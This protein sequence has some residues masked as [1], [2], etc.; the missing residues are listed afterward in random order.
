[1]FWVYNPSSVWKT[2]VEIRNQVHVNALGVTC[3][4][5]SLTDMIYDVRLKVPSPSA[6]ISPG[7]RK[8]LCTVDI[9]CSTKL[10]VFLLPL[11][12]LFTS[13]DK[14]IRK[15]ISV[16]IFAPTGGFCLQSLVLSLFISML[17]FR[18]YSRF[19]CVVLIWN[20]S[21]AAA[22]SNRSYKMFDGISLFQTSSSW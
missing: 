18:E 22:L 8:I 6:I 20:T 1:M 7:C 5:V 11:G 14:D 17:S 3:E 12:K 4:F 16:H 2:T 19:C 9:F 10:T 15:Q 13:R 21:V